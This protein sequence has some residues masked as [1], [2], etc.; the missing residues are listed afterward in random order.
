[1]RPWSPLGRYAGMSWQGVAVVLM[2]V[3]GSLG[4]A[5]LGKENLAMVLAGAA[6]GYITAGRKPDDAANPR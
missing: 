2:F 3:A 1:M 4:A 5:A 6:A